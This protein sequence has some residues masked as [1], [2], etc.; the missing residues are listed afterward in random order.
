LSSPE[1]LVTT[2]P[3][4]TTVPIM[5]LWHQWLG[6]PGRRTLQQTLCH[7]EFVPSKQP[8]VCDSCQR[9]KHV[10]LPFSSSTS[11]SYVPFQ[12]VHADVW[13]YPVSSFSGFK[14]YLVL[15]DD[16]THYIW[17]FPLR[18]KSDVF[19]CLVAFHAYIRTQFQLP[20]LALQ[21]DNGKEFDNLALHRHC[22]SHGIALCLSCPYTSS[23]NG[24]AE[25]IFV[26]LTTVFVV[27]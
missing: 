10:R 12:L 1:A 16:F 24:K 5:D 15:V 13:T 26:H 7:L 18:A 2:V 21:T 27:F 25:H 19:A 8:S 9:G 3:T 14:Y 6:H 20:L 4:V 17:T 23:Q 11:I 22:E